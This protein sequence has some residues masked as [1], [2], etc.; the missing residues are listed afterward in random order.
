[1]KMI[2]YSEK[3]KGKKCRFCRTVL[4]HENINYYDH[5]A[6]WDVEGFKKKQWLYVPCHGCGH[7]W[8][9]EKLGIGRR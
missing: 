1:M 7:D 4:N 5:E 2:E 8:S 9:L 3:I 6:G